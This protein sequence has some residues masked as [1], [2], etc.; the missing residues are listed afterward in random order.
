[1]KPRANRAPFLRGIF[2]RL[3]VDALSSVPGTQG[4]DDIPG[5]ALGEKLHSSIDKADVSAA[6]M[7]AANVVGHVAINRAV[8]VREC[9]VARHP[10][11][12]GIGGAIRALRQSDRLAQSVHDFGRRQMRVPPPADFDHHAIFKVESG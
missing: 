6:R 3:L 7:A 4:A 8:V 11:S 10:Q 2:K 12:A 9:V 5:R 1:M